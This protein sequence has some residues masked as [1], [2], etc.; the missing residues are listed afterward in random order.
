MRTSQQRH[1]TKLG[2]EVHVV[3]AAVGQTSL[4]DETWTCPVCD[5]GGRDPADPDRRCPM[6]LGAQ[7]LDFDPDDRSQIPF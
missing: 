1:R 7:L 5:G 4:L 6:C 2:S 3:M